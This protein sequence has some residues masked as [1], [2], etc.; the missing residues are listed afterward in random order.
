MP[1]SPQFNNRKSANVTSTQEKT[2]RT[3]AGMNHTVAET[4]GLFPLTGD[5]LANN[6]TNVHIEYSKMQN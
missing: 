4:A 6:W 1:R 2:P 3:L 5:M